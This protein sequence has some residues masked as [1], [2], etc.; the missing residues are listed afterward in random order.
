VEEH[1]HDIITELCK[2]PSSLRRI[3]PR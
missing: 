1:V 2:T 3:R